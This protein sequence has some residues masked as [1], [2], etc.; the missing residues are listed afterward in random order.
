[1]LK[2]IILINTK[3][4]LMDVNNSSSIKEGLSKSTEKFDIIIDDSSH[5]FEH[6][7][8]IV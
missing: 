8:N 7:I 4:F 5:I 1:M 2:M 3:Y 6:Q